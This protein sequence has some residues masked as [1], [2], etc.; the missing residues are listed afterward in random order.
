MNIQGVSQ[1]TSVQGSS[2]QSDPRLK[3]LD[4]QISNLRKSIQEVRKNEKLDQKIKEE[5]I[6]GYDQQIQSLQQERAQIQA[7]GRQG[8][9]KTEENSKPSVNQEAK[10]E[11]S[12]NSLLNEHVQNAFVKMESMKNTD[13]ALGFVREQAKGELRMAE[14]NS[15]LRD[16]DPKAAAA[17]REKLAKVDRAVLSRASKVSENFSKAAQEPAPASKDSLEEESSREYAS[18]GTGRM[19]PGQ[20]LNDEA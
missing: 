14:S 2:Q 7:E 4:Q 16:P 6:K 1:N 20:F 9:R 15:Y 13:K 5:K 12:E 11:N 10:N 18:S 8:N 19:E 17:A 3:A